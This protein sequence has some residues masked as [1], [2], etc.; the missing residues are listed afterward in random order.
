MKNILTVLALAVTGAMPIAATAAD[1]AQPATPAERATPAEPG[2][3]TP[4]AMPAE[5]AT[6]AERATPAGAAKGPLQGVPPEAGRTELPPMFRELD[7]DKDGQISK[8]EAKRSAETQASFDSMD[9]DRN[10]KISLIEWGAADK[11]KQRSKQ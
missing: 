8:G 10:G 11:A 1:P 3:K 4:S 9:T 6:P 2:A 7:Q 5:P